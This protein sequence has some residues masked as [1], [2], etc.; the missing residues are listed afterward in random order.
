MF[1]VARVRG[2]TTII[3]VPKR[4]LFHHNIDGSLA[5][6]KGLRLCGQ[7]TPYQRYRRDMV[8]L[9]RLRN[10]KGT[11]GQMFG[12]PFRWVMETGALDDGLLLHSGDLHPK[13]LVPQRLLEMKKDQ[14]NT[15][16]KERVKMEWPLFSKAY[17]KERKPHRPLAII[18]FSSPRMG[19]TVITIPFLV[20]T[21]APGAIYLGRKMEKLLKERGVLKEVFGFGPQYVIQGEIFWKE[22]VIINPMADVIPEQYD[23]EDERNGYDIRVN[24]I[25]YVG[26]TELGLLDN[27]VLRKLPI[28]Y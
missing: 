19:D 25:G 10:L 9:L 7:S 20:D 26:L 2:R 13:H 23:K 1:V 15:H 28:L 5:L 4:A 17:P 18:P 6:F 12:Q 14:F 22:H 8:R 16:F 27:I 21:G 11:L 24:L 3:I